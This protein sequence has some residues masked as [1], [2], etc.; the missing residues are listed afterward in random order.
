MFNSPMR[1]TVLNIAYHGIFLLIL[2]FLQAAVFPWIGNDAI[3]LLLVIA[4]AGLSH[5]TGSGT[6]AVIGLFCGILCD[7]ALGKPTVVY[8][9]FLSILG[10]LMGY[11]GETVLS[12]RFPS[13]ILCCFTALVLSSFIQMFDLLF[14][15]GASYLHLL[16]TAILQTIVSLI[17]A[18]PMY[19]VIKKLS[20]Q[21]YGR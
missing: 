6:G 14:F 15:A 16:W 19:P 10:L 20:R 5:F 18:V 4:A 9:V 7:V 3:P 21:R 12:R 1:K 11:L 8:T 2:Y 13:Y 17:C